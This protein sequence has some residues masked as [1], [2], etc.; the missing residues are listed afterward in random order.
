MQYS[1]VA[2][3]ASK[4]SSFAVDFP[5]PV[6]VVLH[7]LLSNFAVS[8]YF[9]FSRKKSTYGVLEKLPF[10][11]IA[12]LG[13]FKTLHRFF[14][15]IL[16]SLVVLADSV[17]ACMVSSLSTNCL[18]SDSFSVN[19]FTEIP[20]AFSSSL[21]FLQNFLRRR[22]HRSRTAFLSFS[23]NFG[24]WIS[25]KLSNSASQA[26]SREGLWV[27]LLQNCFLQKKHIMFFAPLH[28]PR[29]K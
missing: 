8:R 7:L 2:A 23:W 9:N 21:I 13:L 14:P 25:F 26:S 11:W 27:S 29:V 15:D 18:I 1:F 6:P 20:L 12:F 22:F 17:F 10:V 5:V 4:L 19:S 24:E 3:E 16:C 28:R